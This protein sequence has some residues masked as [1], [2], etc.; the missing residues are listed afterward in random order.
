VLFLFEL[1]Q[2]FSSFLA[3][4]LLIEI[5]VSASICPVLRVRSELRGDALTPEVQG[6]K[7]SVLDLH[8]LRPG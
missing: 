7:M 8:L 6:F 2:L 3:L 5:G 1:A 4:S